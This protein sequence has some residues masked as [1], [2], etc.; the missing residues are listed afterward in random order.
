MRHL[1][2]FFKPAPPLYE[3][4]AGNIKPEFREHIAKNIKFVLAYNIRER[5]GKAAQ[6]VYAYV[7]ANRQ[8]S[9]EY[10]FADERI[11]RETGCSAGALAAC[12]QHWER[13]PTGANRIADGK[14]A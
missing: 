6:Q 10:R 1:W 2:K 14:A 3:K 12:K 8:M 5:G 11:M 4:P 7:R 13:D 9:P